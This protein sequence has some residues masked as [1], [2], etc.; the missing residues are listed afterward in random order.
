MRRFECHITL[1]KPDSILRAKALFNIAGAASMKCSWITGDPVLGVGKWF[2]I[3]GYNTSSETL[4]ASM[5]DVANKL[6]ENGFE[7][8]REKNGRNPL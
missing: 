7:V 8:I 6:R 4:L 1:A 3:S 2:Y 5:K